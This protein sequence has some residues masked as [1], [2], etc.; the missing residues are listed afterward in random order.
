MRHALGVRPG[1]VDIRREAACRADGVALRGGNLEEEPSGD[2]IGLRAVGLGPEPAW[3]R[4]F[5][6]ISLLMTVDN[7]FL[8]THT[9][10][11]AGG[12]NWGLKCWCQG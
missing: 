2:S 10:H 7:H 6:V 8:I 4:G 1:T 9:R 11:V 5:Q 12:L 3:Q